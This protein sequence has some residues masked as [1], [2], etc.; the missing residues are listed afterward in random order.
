MSS[1]PERVAAQR[2]P[3]LFVLTSQGGS[4]PAGSKGARELRGYNPFILLN[5]R[6]PNDTYGGGR[7]RLLK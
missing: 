6:I 2:R 1:Y 3:I 7:G 4:E 5:R